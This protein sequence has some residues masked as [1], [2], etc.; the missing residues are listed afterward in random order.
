MD[1]N[2]RGDL[3]DNDSADVLRWFGWRDLTAPMDIA[4]ALEQVGART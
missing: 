4:A 3:W 2:L 1:I